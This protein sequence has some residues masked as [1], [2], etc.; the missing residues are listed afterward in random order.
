MTAAGLGRRTLWR[1]LL[2]LTGGI[3]VVGQLPAGPCVIVANHS[4][5]ADTAALLAS[6]PARRGPVVAAA[7]DYWFGARR[8]R[9]ICSWLAGA[10]PVRR[11]GGGSADLASAARILADGRDV[12]VFPEG[13]RSRDGRLGSF[14][15]GAARLAEQ[16]GAP[17]VPVGI[18]GTRDL[19]PVHGRPGRARVTV[20]IGAPAGDLTEAK[21][22]VADLATPAGRHRTHR[23]ETG[24]DSAVRRTVAAFTESRAGAIAV[25]VWAAAE[26]LAWP[27]IPEF[28]L[29][30]VLVAAPRRAPRLAL[31]AALGSIAGGALMYVLASHGVV[32]PAPL[33]TPRM[34]EVV[35]AQIAAEGPGALVHQPW[36]GIPFKVYGGAAGAAH[37]GLLPFLGQ[38]AVSRGLRILGVGLLI[39]LFGFVTQRWRRWYAA[40][41]AV[42]LIVFAAGLAGVLRYWS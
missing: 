36:S 5:H 19:L 26:A 18:H 39:G 24:V 2:T 35:T 7:A 28:L 17:L 1:G 40:Y 38:A 37:V 32:L 16:A 8:R 34:H 13:T 29:A 31:Y 27:L 10:F 30:V 41:L 33:T 6:V 3:R 22:A 23:A 12:I 11:D 15:S 4:S 42:F 14:H 20:R 9:M 21:S 25:A